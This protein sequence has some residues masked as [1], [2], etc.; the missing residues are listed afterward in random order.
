MLD[1]SKGRGQ[2]KSDFLFQR[3]NGF[4]WGQHPYL[5]YRDIDEKPKSTRPGR[6]RSSVLILYCPYGRLMTQKKKPKKC[7]MG[8]GDCLSMAYTPLGA[9]GR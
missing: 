2:T 5:E 4:A 7:S 6:G 8:E 1:R 3:L 9:N